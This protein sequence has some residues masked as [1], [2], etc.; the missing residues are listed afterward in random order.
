M[1]GGYKSETRNP[2]QIQSSKAEMTKTTPPWEVLETGALGV[3]VCLGFRIWETG[4]RWYLLTAASS[5]GTW[6][7]RK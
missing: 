2:K 3:L 7:K 4:S 1:L 6:T 5:C